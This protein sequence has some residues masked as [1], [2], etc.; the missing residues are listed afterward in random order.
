MVCTLSHTCKAGYDA[1][2][3]RTR[4]LARGCA[5]GFVAFVLIVLSFSGRGLASGPRWVAGPTYFNSSVKGTPIVWAGGQV[6][7]YID[8]GSLS[9][10]MSQSQTLSMLN[11]AAAVWNGVP[12]AAVSITYGGTLSEDVSGSNVTANSPSGTGATLPADVQPTA[13]TRPLGVIMDADGS[14][15]DAIYGSGASDPAN[16]S[17]DAVF[18]QVDNMT[19]SG[20]IAHALMILNGRCATTQAQVTLMT[21][22]V[23]RGLGRI[24][25]LDWSQVNESMFAKDQITTNDLTGWPVMHAYERLCSGQTYSCMPNPLTLRLDDIAGLNRLYPVTGAN[26]KSFANKQITAQNTVSVKGTIHF[27]LG[28]GM[29]GVNVVLTPLTNGAPDVR[30]TVSTVSGAAFH[31]NAGNPIVGSVDAEGNALNKFGTDDAGQEGAFD[32]SG[33]PLPAGTTAASYQLTFEPVNPLYIGTESVGPYAISQV[34]PSGTMPVLML[35]SISAGAAVTEDVVITD[36]AVETHTDDGSEA[37]PNLL[38][39]NGEWLGRLTGYGHTGWYLFEARANRVF[40]VECTSLD[41][42]GMATP[43]KAGVM[44]G[45]WNGSDTLGS[46]PALA[47][48]Q[49]FNGA[50]VGLTTLNAQTSADGQARIAV[51]DMRG[52]GRPDYLYR[53]RVLYADTVF[54]PRLASA[55]GPI[56]ISGIGFRANSQVLVNG[57]SATVTSVSPTAIT[58]VAPASG[59]AT[60]AVPVVVRDP[61]TLGSATILDEL[62]YDAYGTDQIGMVAGPS[63]TVSQGVPTPFTVR[64][65]GANN[66]TPAANVMVSFTLQQGSATMGCGSPCAVMTNGAGIATVM[67]AA[68]SSNSTRVQAALSSGASVVAEFTGAPAPVIAAVTPSLYVAIGAQVNW[69]PTAIVLNNG[70]PVPNAS[71][72]WSATS[73]GVTMQSGNATNQAGMATTTVSAGP[74]VAGAT[75]TFHACQAAAPTAC[76]PFNVY[77]VHAELAGLTSISGT[78]QS[79]SFSATPAPVVL[80]VS[81]AVGHPL[82]GATVNF[83]ETLSAWQAACPSEGRCPA[84]E[85][86]ATQSVTAVSN[87]S[88]LVTL[89]PLT[90]AGQP[91]TLVVNAATGQQSSLVFTI[92]QHP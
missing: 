46:M 43:S 62:S 50:A 78:V 56:V 59:G 34:A 18:T 86:I 5:K 33:V 75:A 1:A 70:S 9:S 24:L 54:P 67:L 40:T 16:C 39:A 30:Y 83:Y 68:A 8:H 23:V 71:V 13:T 2:P 84:A 76:A 38:D 32:L 42:T 47:T 7:L 87:A 79:I 20:M 80:Q 53:A 11:Q 73:T 4:S 26:I 77:A 29:Q 90:A 69:Q 25:G 74:L 58:A 92:V 55:G 35:S 28:Q 22:E 3:R 37:A 64:V 61:S 51:A 31:S 45:F 82:A 81:D 10:I 57:V 44:L 14:V 88:G 12:T 65:V 85:T 15:I 91:T 52:D 19:T 63:G 17:T 66:V 48:T 41:E 21:Y 89:A 60:G 27:K 49:P 72:T 6:S 36:S